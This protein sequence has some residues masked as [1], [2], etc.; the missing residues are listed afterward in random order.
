MRLEFHG[1]FRFFRPSSVRSAGCR[2]GRNAAGAHWREHTSVQTLFRARGE[3]IHYRA[4]VQRARVSVR[5][6]AGRVSSIECVMRLACC[7]C[8]FRRY[9]LRLFCIVASVLLAALA[10]SISPSSMAQAA[11]CLGSAEEVRKLAPKAWP[12]WTYG[13][14]GEKCWYSGK[15][16]VFAK[17][18]SPE[19][20]SGPP[21]RSSSETNGTASEERATSAEQVPQPWALEYR[22]TDRFGMRPSD[23]SSSP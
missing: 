23:W 11:T 5:C 19:R 7:K 15:K 9:P 6:H 20:T 4:R 3:A 17:T 10:V 18:T 12:K 13:P 16:P 22:W 14:D 2:R 1:V 8:G 21:A